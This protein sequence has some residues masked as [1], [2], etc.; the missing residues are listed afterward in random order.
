MDTLKR[1]DFLRLAG[2]AGG[3]VFASG[4]P[5][6]AFG[7]DEDFYFVQLSDAHWGFQGP[8]NPDARGTLPKAVAAVNALRQPPDFIMFTGDLTHTTDDPQER[9]RR[10]REFQSVIAGL[11]VRTIHL[12]P[13]E[14]DASLDAGAAYQELF[15][16]THYTFDHKGVHFIVLDNVSDP[17][18][19]VGDAQRAWLAADLTRQ[20]KGAR[21]VV[22][23]HRPLFDLY[24]QW[25]WATRDGA[26]VID[27]LMPY[28]NVTVFY[29]HI[30][31][32]HHH[33]TGHIAHH[34]ARSLMFPLPPPGSQP[35]RLPVPWDAAQPYRGLGW[36]E[37]EA[38]ATPGAFAL[39]EQP[40]A[41]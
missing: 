8:A 41:T 9:R 11:G 27:T 18:G 23:T 22:F 17:A 10:L 12:M 37:I 21:I 3:A 39:A 20:P 29:G 32:E 24:P 5:G 25:D 6:W 40:I 35:Q 13:G 31:Q 16:P 15:G 38:K 1:R 4:L 34:A 7:R 33:T 36:R 2:A 14:H 28:P 26:Q 19:R 30:H